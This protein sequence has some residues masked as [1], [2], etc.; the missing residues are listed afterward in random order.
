MRTVGVAC[1]ALLV[2]SATAIYLPGVAPKEYSVGDPVRLLAVVVVVGTDRGWS[3]RSRE[4]VWRCDEA[5]PCLVPA[6]AVQI[7]LKVN[8]LSSTA[9]ALSYNYYDLAFCRVRG[10]SLLTVALAC[11][12][13]GCDAVAGPRVVPAALLFLKL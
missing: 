12:V 1:V 8:K 2:S 13:T 10:F 11:I 9:S 6:V 7:E 3:V 5:A 4:A